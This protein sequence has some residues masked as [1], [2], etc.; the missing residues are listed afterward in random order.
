MA[1][2]DMMYIPSFMKTGTG[3]EAILRFCFRDLRGCNVGTT[4]GSAEVSLNPVYKLSVCL[5]CDR[6]VRTVI[7]TSRFTALNTS[8]T[9]MSISFVSKH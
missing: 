6:N 8:E 1:S 3:I 4:D 7:D 2:C 9:V 5:Y